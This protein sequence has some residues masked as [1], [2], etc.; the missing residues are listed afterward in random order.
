MHMDGKG[1]YPLSSINCQSKLAPQ[2]GEW[3]MFIKTQHIYFTGIW[4]YVQV[5]A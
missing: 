3:E 1:D 2:G 5:K 4:I